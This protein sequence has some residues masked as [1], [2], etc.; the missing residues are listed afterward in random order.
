[1]ADVKGD[2][3]SEETRSAD[4]EVG[5]SVPEQAQEVRV[6]A[7]GADSR[8]KLDFNTFAAARKEP[9]PDTVGNSW[10]NLGKEMVVKFGVVTQG[11]GLK[12]LHFAF[13]FFSFLQE[14]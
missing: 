5:G 14:R 9:E 3:G 12:R 7:D 13:L 10:M 11:F 1:M 4:V 6:S 2:A 8:W